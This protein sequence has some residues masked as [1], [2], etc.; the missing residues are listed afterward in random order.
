MPG[1]RRCRT[2]A[3]FKAARPD[4]AQHRGR[5]FDVSGATQGLEPSLPAGPLPSRPVVV[6]QC[7]ASA[8]G[9]RM[10]RR[11]M[12]IIERSGAL[13]AST[14]LGRWRAHDH[15]AHA[16]L[17]ATARGEPG[18][19]ARW[20]WTLN[21]HAC[22]LGVAPRFAV[23]CEPNR[24]SSLPLGW[25]TCSGNWIVYRLR[26]GAAVMVMPTTVAPPTQIATSL[27][28]LTSGHRV[29]QR[30]WFSQELL[31]R[32]AAARILRVGMLRDDRPGG[33]PCWDPEFRQAPRRRVAGLAPAQT[34]MSL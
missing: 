26:R 6:E 31:D 30:Y 28:V 4:S 15:V 14:G 13:R 19:P 34:A 21:A 23:A 29:G 20:S 25:S 17:Q 24:Q 22:L 3:P 11:S 32:S 10:L 16:L 5:V 12:A 7:Q 9:L 8:D 18:D 27:F 33:F 2:A 1:S